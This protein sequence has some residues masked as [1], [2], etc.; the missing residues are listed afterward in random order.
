VHGTVQ[1][2]SGLA[3]EVSP[4]SVCVHGDTPGAVTLAAAIRAALDQAGVALAPFA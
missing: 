1:T 3:L 4:R 2:I